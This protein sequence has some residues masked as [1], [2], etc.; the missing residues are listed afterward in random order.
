MGG[1]HPSTPSSP[2]LSRRSRL[3]R[4][5]RPKRHGPPPPG[6][7]LFYKVPMKQFYVCI[8]ASRPGGALYVGVTNDLVRRVYEPRANAI[9]SNASSISKSMTLPRSRF[10]ARR[11][12]NTGRGHGRPTLLDRRTRLGATCMMR[13]RFPDWAICRTEGHFI[14]VFGTAV[15]SRSRSPGRARR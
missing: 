14:V 11:T 1:A 13:S 15:P 9:T 10:N 3:P 6:S 8:M 2:G 4:H 5:G 7:W 12:S